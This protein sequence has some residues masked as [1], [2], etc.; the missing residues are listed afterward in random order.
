MVWPFAAAAGLLTT[1]WGWFLV[2]PNF[3]SLEAALLSLIALACYVHGAP[4]ARDW[5]VVAG[6]ASGLD[7]AHQAE[8]W[9]LHGGGTASSP[10]GHRESSTPN[11]IGA[12][13]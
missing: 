13:A 3:Y 12:G 1:V 2:T 7:R 11:T 9:R 4:S 5:M 6:I 10:S 8:R